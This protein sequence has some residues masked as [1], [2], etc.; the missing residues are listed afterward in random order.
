M[1]SLEFVEAASQTL[2]ILNYM[3]KKYIDMI[4]KKFIEFL[5]SNKLPN[6]ITNIDC[7][8]KLSKTG[9]RRKTKSLLA[10]IYLNYWCDSNQKNNYITKLKENEKKA[11]KEL[12]EKYKVIF[13]K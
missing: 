6:Y 1:L 5:E 2:E 9:L 12:E 8:K 13:V 11:I 10:I 3:D 7:T 4:P